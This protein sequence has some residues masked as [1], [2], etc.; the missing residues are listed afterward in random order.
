VTNEGDIETKD[1]RLDA[2][3][4]LRLFV[5]TKCTII[6]GMGASVK[7]EDF[8][9]KFEQYCQEH[10]VEPPSP[11]MLQ[12]ILLKCYRVIFPGTL[13]DYGGAVPV[14]MNLHLKDDQRGGG[15]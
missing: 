1:E 15:A 9:A 11:Q 2:V 10:G 14:W 12:T 6:I 7:R 13:R 3:D 5:D 4:C 8:Q